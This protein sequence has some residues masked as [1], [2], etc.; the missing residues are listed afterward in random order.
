MTFGLCKLW[1]SWQKS[2]KISGISPGLPLILWWLS[3]TRL[4]MLI[5]PEAWGA[6]LL[7]T[8]W[9]Q[10]RSAQRGNAR[11]PRMLPLLEIADWHLCV[12]HMSPWN[13]AQAWLTSACWM[14]AG[15]VSRIS[16]TAWLVTVLLS[17]FNGQNCTVEG[18]CLFQRYW[19]TSWAAHHRI[20]ASLT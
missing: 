13:W 12:E 20:S 19:Q 1:R 7:S 18:H 3:C 4:W 16:K 15:S 6:R 5:V 11:C 8:A 17:A 9:S 2:L 14:S 10:L